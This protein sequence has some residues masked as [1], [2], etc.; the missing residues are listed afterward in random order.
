[1]SASKQP[2]WWCGNE[3]LVV[4]AVNQQMWSEIEDDAQTWEIDV[5]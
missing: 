2:C 3:A 5:R 4:L 1:M